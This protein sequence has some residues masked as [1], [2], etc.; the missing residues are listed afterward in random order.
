MSGSDRS[1]GTQ[2]WI[3]D[4]KTRNASL[5]ADN[6]AFARWLEND[7]KPIAGGWQY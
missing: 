4:Y 2:Q 7:Y 3:S 6:H 1:I 5:I